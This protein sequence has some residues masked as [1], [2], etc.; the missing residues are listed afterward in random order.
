MYMIRL[1]L[2]A[3][4]KQLLNLLW[5]QQFSYQRG[6]SLLIF[7]G[8][9][10]FIELKFRTC[11]LQ[12]SFVDRCELEPGCHDQTQP[13]FV[14]HFVL[15]LIGCLLCLQC[16]TCS[17]TYFGFSLLKSKQMNRYYPTNAGYKRSIPKQNDKQNRV[18]FDHGNQ[19][20]VHSAQQN[21]IMFKTLIL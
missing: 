10:M 6:S 21:Q 15:E 11:T 18:A 7:L 1:Q 8:R 4:I 16:N 17:S 5:I 12:L 14:Y 3:G 19:V 9:F 13:C 2:L 20:P